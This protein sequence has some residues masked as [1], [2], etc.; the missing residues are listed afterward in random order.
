[1]QLVT[2]KSQL[3]SPCQILELERYIEVLEQ[4]QGYGD[5]KIYNLK[6]SLSKLIKT[7]QPLENILVAYNIPLVNRGVAK[8]LV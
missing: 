7:P 2:E 1:V 6:N 5:K 8:I 3:S 4:E